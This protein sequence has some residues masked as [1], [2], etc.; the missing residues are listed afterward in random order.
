MVY[1]GPERAALLLEVPHRGQAGQAGRLRRRAHDGLGHRLGRQRAD[2]RDVGLARPRSRSRARRPC[3]RRR[4]CATDRSRARTRRRP[5]APCGPPGPSSASRWWRR[6]R[7][8][9]SRRARGRWKSAPERMISRA[10]ANVPS[11]LRTPATTLP[12]SGSMMSPT[13]FTATIAATTRP[14]GMVSAALPMPDFI[15][16]IGPPS[17]PTVAPAPAPTLPSCTGSA[18][19]GGGGLVAAVGRRPDLRVVAD[20]QVEEDRGRHDRHLRDADVVADVV[21]VEPADDAARRVEAERAPAGERDRVHLVDHVQR[22]EQVG[23]ARAGRAAA[24]RD[25]ADRADAVDE[26]RRCSRSAAR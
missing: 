4:W 25:A 26:N 21:L 15:A 14:F 18:R 8:S 1:G 19:R 17:L 20:R 5:S 23:L 9:C 12:V 7:S 11:G 22:V 16:L 2:D 10:S 6:R 3:R 13:A 24:L